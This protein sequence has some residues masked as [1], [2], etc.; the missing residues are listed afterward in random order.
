[1]TDTATQDRYLEAKLRHGRALDAL[2]KAQTEVIEAE[3]ELQRVHRLY[4]D[5]L[6]GGAA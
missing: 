5:E 2:R 6:M 1:M 4:L 3:R